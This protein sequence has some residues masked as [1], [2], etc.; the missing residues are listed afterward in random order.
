M[1]GEHGADRFV[2]CPA[3]IQ[4]PVTPTRDAR[5][6]RWRSA[7]T[8]N[9]NLRLRAPEN[10]SKSLERQWLIFIRVWRTKHLPAARNRSQL[11]RDRRA[12]C[13]DDRP[14]LAFRPGEAGLGI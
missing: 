12:A 8:G 14:P 11:H 9:Q 10:L 7:P 5:R 13:L 3:K 4:R 2:R 6:R 1:M